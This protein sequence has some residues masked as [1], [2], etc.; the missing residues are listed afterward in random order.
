MKDDTPL[1][2]KEQR[3]YHLNEIVNK[4]ANE[5]NQKYLGK[6]VKVLIEGKSDKGNL[7]GYTETM[8]LV[9]VDGSPD[10]IGKIV[11]VEITDIKTWSLDGK[12][13]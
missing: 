8:K 9:N 11:D 12:I 13:K 5:N 1:S 2:V 4:Y 10:N 6:T 7:M 3:L